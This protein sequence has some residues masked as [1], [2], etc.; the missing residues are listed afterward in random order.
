MISALRPSGRLPRL[1]DRREQQGNQNRNN[2]DHDQQL[3]QRKSSPR[4]MSGHGSVSCSMKKETAHS[5]ERSKI[6]RGAR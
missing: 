2:G 3:D 1:L 5:D 6:E 4:G